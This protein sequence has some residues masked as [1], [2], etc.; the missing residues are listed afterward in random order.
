M[1]LRKRLIALTLTGILFS[2]TACE[3]TP[4][5]KI[6]K[7]HIG[8]IAGAVG[9]AWLGSN[10]GKGKGNIA[11]IATGTLLG[12]YLG[13]Q[14]GASLDR[15]DLAYHEQTSQNSL[16]KNPDGMAATWQNPNSGHAGSI[17][18]VRT[19]QTA[20]NQYCR[21]YRQV[22]QI[23]GRAEEALGT[24]CRQNDGSWQIVR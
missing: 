17:T 16:E 10:V 19:Y 18:P 2:L 13:N 20:N 8:G 24:A 14:I 11:A 23:D 15:A 9:G 1:H 4:N 7:E 12:A 22:I 21:E 5:S 3:T 6:R